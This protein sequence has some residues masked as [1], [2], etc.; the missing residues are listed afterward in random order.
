M[1][2]LLIF[3]PLIEVVVYL[4]Q[5]ITSLFDKTSL[6]SYIIKCVYSLAPFYPI[7]YYIF[8]LLYI[9]CVSKTQT[10][11]SDTHNECVVT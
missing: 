3:Q 9:E 10:F 5:I 11:E 6:F 7:F 4:I 8:G 1:A 2:S